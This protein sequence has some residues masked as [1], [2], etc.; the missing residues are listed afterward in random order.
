[1]QQ[2]IRSTLAPLIREHGVL[3]TARE[4]GL[5][6]SELSAWLTGRV[7]NPRFM[8]DDKLDRICRAL[9]VQLVLRSD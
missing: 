3:K 8:R 6:K 1:M 4:A 7:K 9:G 5:D 2:T